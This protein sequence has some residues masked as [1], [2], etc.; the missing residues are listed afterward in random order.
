MT[1][2]SY[3]SPPGSSYARSTTTSATF[4]PQSTPAIWHADVSLTPFKIQTEEAR[5]KWL[6]EEECL[7]SEKAEK[8]RR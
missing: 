2:A 3:A 1:N 6:A 8:D 5:T 7:K 4:S